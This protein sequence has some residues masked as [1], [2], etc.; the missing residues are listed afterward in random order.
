VVLLGWPKD[1]F[2]DGTV[3]RVGKVELIAIKDVVEESSE[4]STPAVLGTLF[5]GMG[6]THEE[7]K[8]LL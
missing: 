7:R 6:Q 4:V 5:S 3:A 1:P 2:D 8:D